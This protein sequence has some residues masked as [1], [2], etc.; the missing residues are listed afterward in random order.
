[1]Q[2][3]ILVVDDEADFVEMLTLRL[4]ANS[5]R[6]VTARSGAEALAKAA[7]ERPDLILLDVL[8]PGMDGGDVALA[9]RQN[10]KLKLV[11]IIF[12]TA[13]VSEAEAKGRRGVIGGELFVA[14]TGDSRKLVEE[15]EGCISRRVRWPEAP[16]K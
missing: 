2:K 15:I 6:V 4:A 12:L 13:V 14:K 8:M 7:A 9:I 1:M 3:T 5:Y 11:P 10:K 16:A